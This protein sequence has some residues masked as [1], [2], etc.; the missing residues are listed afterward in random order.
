MR[1]PALPR[2]KSQ[3][4]R[5]EGGRALGLSVH[6]GEGEALMTLAVKPHTQVGGQPAGWPGWGF[7][8]WLWQSARGPRLRGAIQ[9]FNAVRGARSAFTLSG[10]PNVLT[11]GREFTTGGKRE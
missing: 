4:L 3:V 11:T 1:T 10:R 6:S 9:C 7:A 8:G 5:Q 2:T